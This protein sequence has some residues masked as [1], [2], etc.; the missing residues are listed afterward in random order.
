M[1]DLIDKKL[2]FELDVDGFQP[3]SVLAKKLKT[4]KQVIGYRIKKLYEQ[5]ILLKVYPFVALEELGFVGQ[6]IYFQMKSLS[7]EAENKIA[8]YFNKHENV[9]WFGIYDGRYDFVISLFTLG[10]SGFS[11]VFDKIQQDLKD[12]IVDFSIASYTGIL[13]LKKN[14]L[15]TSKKEFS[16]EFSLVSSSAKVHNID[17]TDKK[18]LKHL[19][20]DGR[21]S[22]L[23]IA[24]KIGIKTDTVIRRLKDMKQTGLIQGS[25]ALINKQKLNIFEMKIMVQIRNLDEKTNKALINYAKYQENIVAYINCIGAWNV[26]LDIELLH[27]KDLHGIVQEIKT[28][29]DDKLIRLEILNLVKEYKYHF[30]PFLIE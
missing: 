1:L 25:R 5:G 19:C 23:Q 12:Y 7:K 21:I 10:K 4:S 29:I 27:F 16:E 11:N 20:S 18:I 17:L 24:Q 8:D 9:V 22:S 30:Y 6:K 14:Y 2:I 15:T 13:A 26:E 3:N 28:I